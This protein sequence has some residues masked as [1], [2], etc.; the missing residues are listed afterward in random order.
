M[1][2]G[3][4]S[5]S[6]Y[7]SRTEAIWPSGYPFYVS[8]W[9][10]RDITSADFLSPYGMGI[11]ADNTNRRVI[12][13]N[14]SDQ[15]T[16]EERSASGGVFV[17]PASAHPTNTWFHIGVALNSLSTRKGYMNTTTAVDTT[18]LV[19][20]TTPTTTW[21][22]SFVPGGIAWPGGV[23]EVSIWNATGWTYQTDY[24]SLD[25]KLRAGQNPINVRNEA[26]QPWSAKLMGYW[27]DSANTITDLSGNGRTMTMTGTLSNFTTGGHPTIDAVTSGSGAMALAAAGHFG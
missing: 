20:P 25:V 9:A 24:D 7:L 15:V 17:V 26:S 5:G 1:A 13:M 3:G 12:Y 22:G 19:T 2:L 16:L 8:I 18:T 4:W 6:N 11:P 14:A 27:I 23:A 21:I 10:Y